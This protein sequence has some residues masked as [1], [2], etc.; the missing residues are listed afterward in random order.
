MLDDIMLTDFKG[1]TWDSETHYVC[2]P[3]APKTRKAAKELQ[4]QINELLAEGRVFEACPWQCQIA[5]FSIVVLGEEHPDTLRA[6]VTVT[7]ALSRRDMQ[8]MALC[9][10]ALPRAARL[11]GLGHP[12]TRQLALLGARQLCI[13]MDPS[14]HPEF[15]RLVTNV[16]RHLPGELGWGSTVVAPV[17]DEEGYNRHAAL[18]VT[19]EDKVK[20]EPKLAKRMAERC[21]AYFASMGTHWLGC[22][23]KGAA[24]RLVASCVAELEGYAAAEPLFAETKRMTQ[25][26]LGAEHMETLEVVWKV[27]DTHTHTHTHTRT[28]TEYTASNLTAGKSNKTSRVHGMRP[29]IFYPMSAT[30]MYIDTI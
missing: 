1:H 10:W 14:E 2:V 27:R 18:L 30:Y 21:V 4:E 29:H 24:R 19:A 26:E 5:M 15:T 9:G 3:S 7:M 23:R 13:S 28:H 20:E 16:C 25:K 11:W 8:A 22:V 12:D 6:V 17:P